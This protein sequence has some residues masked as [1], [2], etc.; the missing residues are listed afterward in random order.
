M[1]NEVGGV[2]IVRK[3]QSN[4]KAFTLLEVL[5]AMVITLVGLLGLL[6]VIMVASESNAKNIFRDESVQVADSWMNW[7]RAKPFD[8]MSSS[9]STKI[10]TSRVRGGNL[11]YS[12]NLTS[13]ALGDNSRR[14]V[15]NV[16]WKYKNMTTH[17][18]LI[19]LKSR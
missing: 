17:T 18:E 3:L 19:S 1:A 14:I 7:L 12:V 13:E 11:R 10:V 6:Q 8:K 16:K 9:Y 15:T 2:V 4:N 5:V